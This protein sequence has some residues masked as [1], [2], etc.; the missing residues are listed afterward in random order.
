MGMKH[1]WINID[2]SQDRRA[3]MEEQ[4]KNNSLDNVRV[5]AITPQDFDEVLEDKRPLTCKHPG[6]VRCEYEYACIS[7]HIKAMI[8]GL[9]DESNDWF[10]VMED[11]I[12]IPFDID[13]NKMI[14]ELLK[15]APTAQLVQL[16]ILYGQTVK[17]LY[18]LSIT[19][20]MPFIKWQYLLP[21][22]GMYIISREGAEIL[23]GK[24]FKNNKYDFTTCEYQVVADV[25]LYSSINSYATTFPFAYPNI[26]LV[27]EIHPEHYEAH[28]ETYL[29]IREVIDVARQRSIP[30]TAP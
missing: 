10:V 24:Y 4:F 16:L 3:F 20:N 11:D 9:K 1:Y 17:A 18:N 23:V 5:S 30:F 22:T 19:Q 14:G 28:K 8:E 15:E 29:D 6:C 26:D 7:S 12:V 2:R 13:Y 27:S 25:A 21:S